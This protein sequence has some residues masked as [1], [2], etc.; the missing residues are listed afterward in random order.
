MTEGVLV[1]WLVAEGD[2]VEEGEIIYILETDKIQ[3]EIAAPVGGTIRIIAEPDET[4]PVG[5]LVA[6]IDG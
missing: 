6:E 1:E 5:E 4:Y 3:N 2:T